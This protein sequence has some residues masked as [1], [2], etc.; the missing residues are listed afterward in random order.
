MKHFIQKIKWKLRCG[1]TC[2][3]VANFDCYIAKKIYR[4]IS[5]FRKTEWACCHPYNLT[6]EQWD[7]I[8]EDIEI[9]FKAYFDE[10]MDDDKAIKLT[11]KAMKLFA[12]YWNS[13]CW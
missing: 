1:M 7:K 12:K 11:N 13:I 3:E 4:G 9:G 2:C 6:T 8:L 10:N 5:E